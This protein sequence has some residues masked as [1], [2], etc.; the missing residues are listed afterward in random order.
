MVESSSA[1]AELAPEVAEA[2]PPLPDP[3]R[4][5]LGRGYGTG[6]RKIAVAR[7]WIKPGPGRILV[8]G[9][10]FEQYFA[11]PVL[12]MLVA[13]PFKAAS[14]DGQYDVVATV[15]GT[16]GRGTPRDNP[17]PCCVP[18]FPAHG[19]EAGRLPYARFAGGRAQEIRTP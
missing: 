10:T 15:R 16:G 8:N 12:Q 17:G 5:A 14:V 9:R 4:D 6:R 1:L 11:R 2:P 18:A 13:Q 19:A 7:V 3:K